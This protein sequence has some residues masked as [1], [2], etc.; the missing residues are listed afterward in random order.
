M[1]SLCNGLKTLFQKVP[2]TPEHTAALDAVLD[3]NKLYFLFPDLYDE[4]PK[5]ENPQEIIGKVLNFQGPNRELRRRKPP[6]TVK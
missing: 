1:V 3:P 5:V 4:T 2:G 6:K